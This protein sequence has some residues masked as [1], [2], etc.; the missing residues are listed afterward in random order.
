MTNSHLTQPTPQVLS[1]GAWRVRPG[2]SSASFS[3]RGFWGAAQVLGE[4]SGLSGIATL[5]SHGRIE[6]ELVIPTGTLN[7][8]IGRRDRHL[9]S[10][11]FFD[12]ERYPEIKFTAGP[13]TATEDGYVLNGQLAVRDRHVDCQL[14]VRMTAGPRQ[15]VTI[16]AETVL[17]RAALGLGHNPL[18]M[19][20]G[21]GRVQVTI[22]LE[23]DR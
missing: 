12:A 2:D 11:D 17:D 13:L 19:I 16:T 15:R 3:A 5:D 6:G 14:P 8:G 23:R 18:G 1:P 7:T 20:R 10:A 4:F 22:V 21:P 9:R